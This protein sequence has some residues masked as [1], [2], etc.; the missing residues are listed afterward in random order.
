MIALLLTAQAADWTTDVDMERQRV[1]LEHLT[2]AAP[3]D[4]HAIRSRNI[5][6]PDHALARAYL[7]ARMRSIHGLVTREES[8]SARGEDDLANLIGVLPGSDPS[9]DPIVVGAHYDSTASLSDLWT[10]SQTHAPGADDD[11]SGCAA[12]LEIARI[13]TEEP[14]F[15][16]TIEFV[17]FDAEE[18]GLAGSRRHVRN[19]EQGVHLMLSLDPIGYNVAGAGWLFASAG[20][21][22]SEPSE[23]LDATADFLELSTVQQL[24]IVDAALIG[25]PRSDHGPFLEAGFPAIHVGTFPQPPTYHT[26]DDTLD[27]V[28]PGF[29][30]DATAII[31]ATVAELA[32]PRE[33]DVQ[34][35]CASAP[36]PALGWA[37]LTLAAMRRRI[38]S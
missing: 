13:L 20:P 10:P 33:P 21:D 15:E 12:V 24:D 38:S 17:L 36:V 14:G 37:L 23:L 3:I 27:V 31:G 5:H 11:A 32:G 35:S 29:V 18:E 6:H 19:R 28:D 8:F 25:E 7:W 26:P 16:R 9:L 34:R 30:R 4:G 2:G 1:D 22:T